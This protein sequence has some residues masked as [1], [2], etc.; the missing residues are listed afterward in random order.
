MSYLV[1]NNKMLINTGKLLTYHIY[2][3]QY[4]SI[5]YG[6]LYNWFAASNAL[7]APAGWHVPTDTELTTLTTYLG[8][9]VVAG[10]KMKESGT[11]HWLTPNTG[12]DNTSGFIGRPGGNRDFNGVF[13]NI[14][15]YGYWWSSAA[16]D[17]TN[18]WNRNLQY[19]ASNSNRSAYDKLN[20]FSIRL[21]KDDSTLVSSLTDIDNNIYPTVKIGN[22]VWTCANWKC[23]KLNDGTPI[24]NVT[25]NATWAGLTTLAYCAY[26]N[27]EANV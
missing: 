5:I 15:S 7:F 27:N 25:V 19:N 3:I 8:G 26:D 24:P 2:N 6:Y 1:S 20:G 21:I 11:T 16:Y 17:I 14:G 10:G 4:T 18:A 23:T 12:A 9:T 13:A 22:Q